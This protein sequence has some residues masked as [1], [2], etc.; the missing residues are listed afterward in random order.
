MRY[1]NVVGS[2]GS[3]VPVFHE[4]LE[5]DGRITITDERMTRFWIT[6]AQ[7][8]D[9]VLHALDNMEGGEIF[10]PKIPS[11]RVTDLAEAIAPG[12]APRRDRHPARREAARDADHLRRGAPRDR[13]GRGVRRDARAPVV[14]EMGPSAVGKPCADDFVYA[15]DTN[16]EWLSIDDL[17]AVLAA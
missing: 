6:L 13:R 8:V 11:M 14:G 4:Q 17:R 1:G 3:V 2:R 7:A 15:S 16:D 12:R 10:I 9:L 5:R